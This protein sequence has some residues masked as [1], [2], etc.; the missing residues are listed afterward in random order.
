MI[1]G[2]L[3]G[4]FAGTWLDKKLGTDPYLMIV[5]I[6]LGLAASI[7]EVINLLRRA[8]H[9]EDDDVDRTSPD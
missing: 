2:P 6:I 3:V 4:Y 8:A 5:L 1:G 7:R 9:E